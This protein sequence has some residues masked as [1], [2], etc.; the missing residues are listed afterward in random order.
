MQSLRRSCIGTQSKV[1]RVVYGALRDMVADCISPEGL[2]HVR[3]QWRTPWG[4]GHMVLD[5]R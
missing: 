1:V 4:R 2:V 5:L 3:L